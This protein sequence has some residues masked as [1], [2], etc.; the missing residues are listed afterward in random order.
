MMNTSVTPHSGRH[1]IVEKVKQEAKKA[2]ALSVYFS[3]W[4]CALAFLAAALLDEMPIPLTIFGF[5]IVKGALSAKFLLISQAFFPIKVRKHD[6]LI[7]SLLLLSFTYVLIV[8][9]LNYLE[10]GLDGLI[11]G[12]SFWLSLAGFDQG[13]P[14]RIF[15]ICIVYWLIVWPYLTL[16]GLRIALGSNA[17]LAILFGDKSA[18]K[19][20]IDQ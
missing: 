20:T 13:N 8:L 10:A 15:A 3:T 11:H 16:E 9:G 5:A 18:P 17:T 1:A 19:N 7:R 2:F 6:G 14:L 4:F 12:K